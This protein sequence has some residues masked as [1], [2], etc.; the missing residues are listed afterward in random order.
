MRKNVSVEVQEMMPCPPI[1]EKEGQVCEM[2]HTNDTHREDKG[3]NIQ[4]EKRKEM[5]TR[6]T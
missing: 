5:E 2:H 3:G 4:H 6:R 1:S